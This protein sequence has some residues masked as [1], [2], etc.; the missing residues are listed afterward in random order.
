MILLIGFVTLVATVASF[1]RLAHEDLITA[2][3]RERMRQRYQDKPAPVWFR[4]FDECFRC[5]AVWISPV[6]TA[7]ALALYAWT[8][9]FDTIEWA[10]TALAWIP[11]SKG[12]SYLAYL[13]YLR[14]EA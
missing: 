8:H 1:T 5:A 4:A 14:E 11:A 13:L 3:W 7:P 9:Q 2:P 12:I 6:F 10:I